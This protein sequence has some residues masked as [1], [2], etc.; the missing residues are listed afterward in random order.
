MN[1]SLWAIGLDSY[2]PLVEISNLDAQDAEVM[3]VEQQ[4]P[5]LWWQSHEQR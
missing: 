4:P 5:F 1:V 3:L 2:E